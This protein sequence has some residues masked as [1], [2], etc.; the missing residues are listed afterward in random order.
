[1]K[2][3]FRHID[4]I[5]SEDYDPVRWLSFFALL[6]IKSPKECLTICNLM[7]TMECKLGTWGWAP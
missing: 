3:L 1:M 5:H 6:N 4:F 7:T 2:L